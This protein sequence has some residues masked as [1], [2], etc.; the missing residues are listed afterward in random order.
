PA[1]Y[2]G[3]ARDITQKRRAEAALQHAIENAE[4]A[5]RAKSEFLANMSHEIRTPMNAILGFSELLKGLVREDRQQS[6]V[7]AITSSG[8]TLLALINDILDLSKIEAGKLQLEYD[9]IDIRV[10]LND[11][12]HIFSQKAEQKDLTLALD[13]A[14]DVPA[15][16][17]LD[18]VRLR[19]ILFNVVG[20]ALKFTERGHVK[21]RAFIGTA[22]LRQDTVELILE[23]EDSGIGIPENEQQRIFEE[24]TQQS[25]QNTKKYGGTGLGLAITK[26]LVEVMR[27][28]ISIRSEIGRGST[29]RFSFPEI[30]LASAAAENRPSVFE[31]AFDL[32]DFEPCKVL[33]ADDIVMNRDLIR[34]FFFGTDHQLIEAENGREAIDLARRE[35]P[36]VI[37]MDVRMPVMDGVQATRALKADETLKTIPIIVV[38]AS[39]MQSEEAVLK[40]ISDGFLRKPISR[41]DLAGQMRNFCRLKPGARKAPAPEPAEEQSSSEADHAARIPELLPHL[42]RCHATWE[43]LLDAP[44]VSEVERFARH[45]ETMGDEYYTP[46][47]RD[48]GKRLAACAARFDLVGMENT[49]QE[50]GTLFAQLK[51]EA[52]AK[53]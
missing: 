1:F 42:E 22:N 53:T 17:L 15:S 11:V 34:A 21:I 49:L 36:D 13:I 2:E 33:V 28:H 4:S 3:L 37:L 48:Y 27:G 32:T 6:Y 47:L 40:P 5:N 38:T 20:N 46:P 35:R 24:F 51:S 8:R 44:L 29:F 12:R 7:Q 16:L 10:V 31:Q 14:P 26:R 39:A 50:F 45:L 25:G 23:V 30:K 18:E 19:Q 9:A 43:K 52:P 41:F